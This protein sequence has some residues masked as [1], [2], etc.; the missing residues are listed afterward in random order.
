MGVAVVLIFG[1]SLNRNVV[2]FL[3]AHG[4]TPACLLLR[5]LFFS[6]SSSLRAEERRDASNIVLV[7]IRYKKARIVRALFRFLLVC[8][9]E[10]SSLACMSAPPLVRRSAGPNARRLFALKVGSAP[11]KRD[12]I[13]VQAR[14]WSL[15]SAL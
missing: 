1:I 11:T 8:P 5:N 15:P 14:V 7:G 6:S 10:F 12:G 4:R 2:I 13:C 3:N 9:S